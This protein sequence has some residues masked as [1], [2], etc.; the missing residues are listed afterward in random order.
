M[1]LTSW[2]LK[3]AVFQDLHQTAL[4]LFYAKMCYPVFA[5]GAALKEDPGGQIYF[6]SPPHPPTHP[7]QNPGSTCPQT[8]TA[9]LEKSGCP[10][11]LMQDCSFSIRF[12]FLRGEVVYSDWTCTRRTVDSYPENC[13]V[14][15]HWHTA[16]YMP[17]MY[18]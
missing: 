3:S 8:R 18:M 17:C 6:Q 16:V 7:H 1:P 14:L 11:Y 13:S 15:S 2:V 4:M 12:F 5:E 10:S 9:F